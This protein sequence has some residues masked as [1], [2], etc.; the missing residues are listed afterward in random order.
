MSPE[1]LRPTPLSASLFLATHADSLLPRT[2]CTP[3]W[4]PPRLQDITGWVGFRPGQG[5][6]VA[7]ARSA[8]HK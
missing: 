8:S 2:P 3:R 7:E 5:C 1:A 4:H 6:P